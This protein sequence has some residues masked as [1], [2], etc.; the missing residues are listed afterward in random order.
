MRHQEGER[1]G[2]VLDGPSAPTIL[3]VDDDPEMRAYLR[4]CLRSLTDRVV[5]AVDGAAALTLLRASG[6]GAFDLVIADVVMP[7]LDG[8]SLRRTLR[9]D[10]E[11]GAPAVLLV[12]GE[13]PRPD[14][15]PI[16]RKPF[17]AAVLREQ[18]LAVLARSAPP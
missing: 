11:I 1:R 12:T 13:S 10:P 15:E 14:D 17:N 6:P 18:V 8:L 5:E 2:G 4:R 7:G 16:L 3:I 9:D